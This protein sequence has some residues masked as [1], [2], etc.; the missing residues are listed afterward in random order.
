MWGQRWGQMIWG[1]SNA[2]PALSGG[3]LLLLSVLLLAVGYRLG[4][5]QRAPR[6]LPW[7]TAIGAALLPVAVVRAATFTVPFVFSNGTTADATQV[8]ANMTAIATEIDRLRK[9]TAV[10]T[11]CEFRPVLS[12]V[13]YQCGFGLGGASITDGNA[14]G[15]SAPVRVPQGALITTVDVWVNDTSSAAD[16][17]LCLYAAIDSIGSYD[18]SVPCVKTSGTPGIVKLTI[19]ANVT[20]GAGSAFELFATSQNSSGVLVGWPASAAHAIR[21]AYA[22]YEM[23]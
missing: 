22:H 21:T 8:N 17:Q 10:V 3:A 2:V 23:P 11:E 18:L 4:K 9:Q 1:G 16:V 20:Q 15:M 14:G 13:A 19:T 5:R 7:L 6:W 12:P